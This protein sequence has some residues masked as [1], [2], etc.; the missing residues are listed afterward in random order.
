MDSLGNR[1]I[2]RLIKI[3]TIFVVALVVFLIFICCCF[4]VVDAGHTGVKVN[5]GKVS[6]TVL[7]EGLHFKAPFIT[8]IVQI[9]NRV[10][11]TEVESNAASKDLQSISSKV[12]V[13]FRVDPS[14]SA[15]IY[16]N[17]G[18][19]YTEVIVNPA[20]QECVKSV[21]ARYNAEQLITNRAA[22]STEM[23][24]EISQKI[25]PYG[26]NVEI[27]NIINFDFSEEF[28]KAIEAKQTA[29]QQALKAEQDLVRVKIEAEQMVEKAKADAESYELKNQQLSD[30]ILMMQFIE[31]WDGKLPT[32]TSSASPLFDISSYINK[33]EANDEKKE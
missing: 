32:V 20:I 15:I 19:D 2:K 13:N 10:L 8:K 29:Q 28:N 12:A 26:L 30:K 16:R 5:L 18:N 17:V 1:E 7:R 21:L 3:G 23:E 11:K 31:K 27:L 33:D 25:N 4:K 14:S 24:K 22:V 9:N 6:D